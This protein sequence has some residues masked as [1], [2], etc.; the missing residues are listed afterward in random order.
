MIIVENQP[1]ITKHDI[2]IQFM[3]RRVALQEVAKG[4]CEH[5]RNRLD[6]HPP[7]PYR[8]YLQFPYNVSWTASL[9]FPF[10]FSSEI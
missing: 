6:S 5:L 3:S 9:S 8:R 10:S 7:T 2:K 4:I 1:E